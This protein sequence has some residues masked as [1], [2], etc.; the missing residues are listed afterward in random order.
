MS[1]VHLLSDLIVCLH[2]HDRFP[3]LRVGV[4]QGETPERHDCVVETWLQVE[5]LGGE[6]SST[7]FTQQGAFECVAGAGAAGTA[8]GQAA[9]GAVGAQAEG[10]LKQLVAADAKCGTAAL[11]GPHHQRLQVAQDP[12]ARTKVA[13]RHQ[14]PE[15]DIII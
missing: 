2:L 1:D 11:A 14:V 5:Q 3:L 4:P 15:D 6:G 13:R 10:Q 8:H 12:L 9:V 7:P